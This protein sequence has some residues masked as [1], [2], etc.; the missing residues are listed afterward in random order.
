[1]IAR[2]WRGWTAAD[3]ADE[4]A[5]HLAEVAL[6]RYAASPGNQSTHVFRRPSGGGVEL[7]TITVWESEEALPDRVAERHPSLVAS[8]TVPA[9]WEVVQPSQRVV[10]AA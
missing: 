6:P 7:M 3:L 8:Q 1:M 4:V 10:R 9:C 5:A 2:L